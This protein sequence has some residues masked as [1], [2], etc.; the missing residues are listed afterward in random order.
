V[1]N[2]AQLPDSLSQPARDAP[3]H[4]CNH[5]EWTPL[6]ALRAKRCFRAGVLSSPYNWLRFEIALLTMRQFLPTFVYV[7]CVSLVRADLAG[8]YDTQ[9]VRFGSRAVLAA[10]HTLQ[11]LCA[12]LCARHPV[13]AAWRLV[14]RNGTSV[15]LGLDAV[16]ALDLGLIPVDAEAFETSRALER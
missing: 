3:L 8:L 2:H 14:L 10:A 15:P 5:T 9:L 1:W 11:P 16:R 6:I 4:D 13:I 12:I 7:K